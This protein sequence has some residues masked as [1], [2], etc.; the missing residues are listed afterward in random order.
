MSRLSSLLL[1]LL[2]ASAT[3]LAAPA[4]IDQASWT[5]RKQ[6]V[7]LPN[8][9]DMAFVEIG[10]PRGRPVVLLHGY[11][12]T[13][14]VWTIVAPYLSEYRLLIPDQRGH[15]DTSKPECCYAPADF[16]YDL[17]LLMDALQV[18]SGTI[19]GSS[20][21]SMVAQL[22]A[23]EYPDRT[24]AIVLAGS[25][26]LPPLQRDHW[27]WSAVTDLQA[28]AN[29]NTAFLKD[30]S[31]AASP[32]PV[33][34]LFVRYFDAE[35]TEVPSTV[36]RSV[37]RELA[38]YPVARRA[39]DVK[40]PVLILSGGKDPIFPSEHHAALLKA[41]PAAEAHVFADLGHNLVVERPEQVGPVLARFLAA[42]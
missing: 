2:L 9:I 27:L 11:T 19:V 32:T 13:S 8:G 12:D 39:A 4:S 40:A 6:H 37:I 25:T 14:R 10:N 28:P 26:A 21:G 24:R 31:P 30:W 36:W 20:M 7:R 22:F 29:R 35:M 41:Y 16:A 23:A 34:P 5:A 33:D 15:G 42:H 38:G 18:P 17:K 3:A 1:P